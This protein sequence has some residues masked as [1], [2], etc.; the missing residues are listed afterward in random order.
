M[1]VIELGEVSRDEEGPP[2]APPVRLD[3]RLFRQIAIVVVAALALLG[4]TGSTPSVRHNIR[5]L[6]S[7]PFEEGDTPIP[8]RPAVGGVLVMPETVVDARIPQDDGTNMI[9]TFTSSTIAR[10]AAT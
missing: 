4:V 8:V 10:D 7:T 3:R 6:W 1:S 9:Q 2:T 5:P